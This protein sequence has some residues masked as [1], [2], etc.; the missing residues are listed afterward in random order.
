MERKTGVVVPLAALYTKDCAAVGEFTALKPFADFCKKTGLSVI[1]LLPVNDTGTQS[2]PYSGLSAFALHPLYI[3]IEAL[4]EFNEALKADKAFA[5]AYHT[6]VK[7]NKYHARF[8]YDKILNEKIRVLHLLYAWIEK[9]VAEEEQKKPVQAHTKMQVVTAVS[10]QS[11]AQQFTYELEK[12]VK[13][14]SWIVSYAV[15][16]N[17]KDSAMQA[18]WKEWP[19]NLQHLTRAQIQIRWSNRALRSSHNFFVWCQMRAAQ[20]FKAAA[21]YV[22]SLG[23]VLKGDIPILMNE[24]SADTWAWPEFFNHDLRA[25][26]PPD[27][28]NPVGQSW[29]FPTY[30][31]DRLE[32][33]NY[34]WWKDRIALASNY[35]SAFRI[36]HVLGFFRIWA[37]NQ[38]ESTAYLGHTEPYKSFTRKELNELGF[39]DGRI[40]WL[41][42]PHVSTQLA[43]DITWNHD[44]SH[45]VLS[46]LC[47]RIGNEELWL[48]KKEITSDRQIYTAPLYNSSAPDF[49]KEK[50]DKLKAALVAKWRDRALIEVTPDHFVKVWSFSASTAWNSLSAEEKER[51]STLFNETEEAN[52]KLWKKQATTLLSAI[53][54]AGNMTACA[55]DLGAIPSV[56][57]E[58]LHKLNILSL[59]V[60]RWC[61][62]WGK[63]AQPYIPFSEYP[64]MSVT[65]TSVHDS[66]TLRQW[67]TNEKQSV[68]AYL[69]L[70]DSEEENPLFE[71][72]APVKAEESF[73]PEIASFCLKSAASSASAWYIN[74]LQDYL[75]LDKKLYLENLD[76]ERINVPGS[77]NNFN[78]TYRMPVT[79]ESLSENVSL[80]NQIQ[81]IVQIHESVKYTGSKK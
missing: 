8:D 42:Q 59:R 19:E 70:W 54:A 66:P 33:D 78:W 72:T 37:V 64:E 7:E 51:L 74:P 27:G 43:D 5:G 67:W 53:T 11:F 61:R 20:Q 80:I 60:V 14:N 15:Y 68:A 62:E 31:W 10:D 50:D 25:G 22:K 49:S 73:T 6:F 9:R 46:I 45:R 17:L 71:N 23:I 75:F 69:K 24:D 4:P 52:E 63:E 40:R 58:V 1:Q 76:D 32:A 12:F 2:S 28:E 26:S 57:P 56:V 79:V 36:D 38:N 21:D 16:K 77:V 35:Y 39:D 48:F 41:S 65:T 55:E 30:N 81:Y 3:N 13:D 34:S 47:D 29:G 44:E 18:S